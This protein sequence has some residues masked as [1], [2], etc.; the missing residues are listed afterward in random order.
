MKAV[1][2]LTLFLLASFWAATA[3]AQYTLYGAPEVLRLPQV[4]SNSLVQPTYPAPPSGPALSPSYP[5]YGGAAVPVTKPMLVPPTGPIPRSEPGMSAI[6]RPNVISRLLAESENKRPAT[7]AACAATDCGDTCEPAE[8]APACGSPWFATAGWLVMG[9]DQADRVWTTHATD[10][11]E[12]QMTNTDDIGMEW[13]NGGEI[14]FGRR[15]CCGCRSWAME[16]VYWGLDPVHGFL[17][18]TNPEDPFT[19][20]TPLRFSEVEFPDTPDPINGAYYFDNAL[21]HRLWRRNEFHNVELNLIRYDLMNGGESDWNVQWAVGVRFFRFDEDLR[22]GS[23]RQ[24]TWGGSGGIYEAYLDEH[25]KNNLVGFQVGFDARS[26][27]W[28]K[29]QLYLSPK[30][31]IYNNYIETTFSLSRGDGVNAEPT[32]GSGVTG[33]YPVHSS[34][35]VFSFLTEVDLGLYWHVTDN[36]S[37]KVGYRLVAATNMGLADHQI[38]HYIVDIPEIEHLDTN[39]DLLLHGAYV[40]VAYNY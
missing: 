3:W 29:L 10:H 28:H 38:P 1:R 22:F 12:D 39:G 5:A 40:G 11:L 2:P 33:S 15:F 31:G 30:L 16:V 6:T 34:R 14:R 36:W 7:D 4:Q 32:S 23:L 37:A 9:R 19:V 8:C 24:G 27:R 20:S 13:A 25:I 17:S 35:D 18:T 26:N 21:E